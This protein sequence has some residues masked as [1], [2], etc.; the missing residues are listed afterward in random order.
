MNAPE[1]NGTAS[2]SEAL[3][4]LWGAKAIAD[5]IGTNVRQAFYLLE[6]R[7]IPARKVGRLWV[8]ERGKL[9][10]YFLEEEGSDAQR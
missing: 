10:R 9:R 2:R 8:A 5:E 1:P 4:L 7:V 6:N 3:D